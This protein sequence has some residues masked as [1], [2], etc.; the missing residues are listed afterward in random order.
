MDDLKRLLLGSIVSISGLG[1]LWLAVLFP[2]VIGTIL[3]IIIFIVV[4]YLIGCM[5]Y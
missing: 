4:S 3:T 2:D 1:V 5:I